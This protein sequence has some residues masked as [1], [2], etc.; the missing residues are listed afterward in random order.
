MAL[1]YLGVK[2]IKNTDQHLMTTFKAETFSLL[3][4]LPYHFQFQDFYNI[5][6]LLCPIAD[7]MNTAY[8][9]HKWLSP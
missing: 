8:Q 5:P 3:P 1:H 6:I 4:P 7:V 2:I 9:T